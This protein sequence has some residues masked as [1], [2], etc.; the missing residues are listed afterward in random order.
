MEQDAWTRHPGPAPLNRRPS[1]E[2]VA[3]DQVRGG[4]TRRPVSCPRPDRVGHGARDKADGERDAG[5]GL[6]LQPALED[7][8]AHLGERSTFPP[9]W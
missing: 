2:L 8:W 6:V 4:E 1:V 9:Q 7:G 3:T 5:L